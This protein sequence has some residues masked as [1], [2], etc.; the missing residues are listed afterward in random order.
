MTTLFHRQRT[1]GSW[2]KAHVA[3]FVLLLAGL[4]CVGWFLFS[5]VDARIYQSYENYSLDAGLRGEEPTI[6]G[7]FRHLI[8]GEDSR[9]P[10]AVTEPQKRPYARRPPMA[11]GSLIGRIEIPRIEISTVVREGTDSK[12]LKRSA[13]HVPETAL[14]GE[15][16]NV[17]IAAHRDSF[18]RNL[19]NVREGD[20]IRVTTTWG[21]FEYQVDSLQIVLPKNIE[22]LDPTPAPSMTLVTCY[23][24]NY[25]GSAPK[26]FIVRARQVSPP[27]ATSAKAGA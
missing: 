2:R 20:T 23:P 13:G 22:V 12:T 1:S 6:S 17:G 4:V 24:F 8:T 19:R 11:T 7:Y 10:A 14:P 18:F 3:E 5:I 25:V 21:V 27:V 9:P 26:R 15:H 16:G